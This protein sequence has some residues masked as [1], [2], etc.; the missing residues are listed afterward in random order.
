[1]DLCVLN[2]VLEWCI[3][4]DDLIS[5]RF[6][7]VSQETLT[8]LVEDKSSEVLYLKLCKVYDSSFPEEKVRQ[9]LVVIFP[10]NAWLIGY[11]V[12]HLKH[13]Y[14]YLVLTN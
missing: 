5:T 11:S 9:T 4:K 7:V 8:K 1:M 12:C 14:I 13:R 6:D 10:C 2:I 3:E